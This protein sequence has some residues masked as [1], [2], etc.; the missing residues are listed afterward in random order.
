MNLLYQL[1]LGSGVMAISVLIHASFTTLAIG[2]LRN[3][4]IRHGTNLRRGLFIVAAVLWS[5]LSICAQCWVWAM[6]LFLLGALPDFET[7]LY[8]ITVTFTTLG[9]GDVVLDREWRLLGSF[10]AAN[11]PIIIGW[12]TAVVFLVV[13]GVYGLNPKGP[14]A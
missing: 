14:R 2:W 9:Y 11:G 10:A 4:P 13:Q 3:H 1:I 8:F 5:F 6:V 7:T 12:T